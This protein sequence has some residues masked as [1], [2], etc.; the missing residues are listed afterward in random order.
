LAGRAIAAVGVVCGILAIGLSTVSYP[1]FSATYVDDG[2]TVAFLLILLSLASHFPAE[3][4]RDTGAAVL[5]TAAFGFLLYVPAHQAFDRLG[6]LG[7]GGWLGL[8]TAL[9][10]IGLLVLKRDRA[11][12]PTRP[13]RSSVEASDPGLL[14]ALGGI[15]LIVVGIWF[16]VDDGGPSFWSS[17]HTLGILM[18]LLAALNLLLLT[19]GG[20]DGALLWACVTFGLV[21][22]PWV[23]HAF[24]KFG[25]L[26]S[27]GWLEAF[28]GLLLLGGVAALR[29]A[30]ARSARGMV[31]PAAPATP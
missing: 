20:S 5:G 28:G 18:L 6:T 1:G 14:V 19:R 2:T 24:E 10:P 11:H 31:A 17:S 13:A 8:C 29:T 15:V 7:S 9:I 3:I 22:Y 23:D 26:G 21:V 27:G 12:A 4:G 30:A 25:S 16:A